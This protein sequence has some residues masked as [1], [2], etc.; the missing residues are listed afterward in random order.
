MESR[1]Y[2]IPGEIGG[3]NDYLLK[4]GVSDIESF[5]YLRGGE[6]PDILMYHI[7]D[8]TILLSKSEIKPRDWH[9]FI[10]AQDRSKL[11]EALSRFSKL[12]GKKL[13]RS[14][15]I[16]NPFIDVT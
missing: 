4:D 2:Y 11:E 16:R 5:G 1:S 9:M 10:M 7:L 14:I 13:I 3:L 12:V 6:D 8:A 15:E